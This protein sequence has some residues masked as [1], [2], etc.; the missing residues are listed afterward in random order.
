M[1]KSFI[2]AIVE[3]QIAR[4]RLSGR[5]MMALNSL[6]INLP[7]H[8]TFQRDRRQ[9]SLPTTKIECDFKGVPVIFLTQVKN[10]WYTLKP[11]MTN[12]SS[13]YKW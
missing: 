10:D 2:W 1:I 9:T 4:W 7:G 5:C 3:T 11:F 8:F 13:G 6:P 12:G